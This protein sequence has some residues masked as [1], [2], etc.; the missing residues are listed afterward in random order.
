MR[1]DDFER[2][3][4]RSP[5]DWQTRLIYSD[6]LEEEG[7]LLLAEAQRWMVEQRF[8]PCCIP[9]GWG[10]FFFWRENLQLRSELGL[11]HRCYCYSL[12]REA[13]L[14][15]ARVL[16]G[17]P[18]PLQHTFVV[19][20]PFRESF[21]PLSLLWRSRNYYLMAHGILRLSDD[22]Y[23]DSEDFPSL[24]EH[25]RVFDEALLTTL[26]IV[27]FEGGDRLLE[28]LPNGC[29]LHFNWDEKGVFSQVLEP[30]PPHPPLPLPRLTRS[31]VN[32]P[33]FF[34]PGSGVMPTSSGS[35]LLAPRRRGPGVSG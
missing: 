33:G 18:L 25:D 17:R 28:A 6:C 4:D 11:M 1:K 5:H 9:D 19:S 15:M 2:L 22:N 13:E 3:L 20:L 16:G 10:W 32:E 21:S 31:T 7:D 8:A 26:G 14:A 27:R 12:R 24:A 29:L 30:I 35:P 23:E 34:L